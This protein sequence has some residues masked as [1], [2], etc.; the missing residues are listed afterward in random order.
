MICTILKNNLYTN[1]T[2]SDL[3]LKIQS[4]YLKERP[5]ISTGMEVEVSQIIKE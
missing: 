3:I 5:M 1:M 2:N 4:E